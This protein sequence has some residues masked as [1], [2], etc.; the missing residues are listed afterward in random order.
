MA[1]PVY[2]GALA[3]RMA[4]PEQEHQS[5]TPLVQLLHHAVGKRLPSPA[6]MGMRLSSLYRQHGVQQQ[7]AL[8]GPVLQKAVLR[9]D[10]A[11]NIV[12]QLLVDVLQRWWNANAGLD[13]KRQPVRLTWPVVG[14]LPQDHHLHGLE[15][16]QR[17]RAEHLISRRINGGTLLP[18][19]AHA[20][21]Q[22]GEIRLLFFCANGVGPGMHNE[23]PM[24]GLFLRQHHTSWKT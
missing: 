21:P 12:H 2:H 18:R 24:Q 1:L 23:S 7:H 13:R 15:R 10:K 6:R 20:R 9:H 14:I 16:R 19:L 8:L 4:T 22:I 17:K 11:G 3:L 5:V